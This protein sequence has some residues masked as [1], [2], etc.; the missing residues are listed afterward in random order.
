[1]IITTSKRNEYR[2]LLP[3]ELNDKVCDE[4]SGNNLKPVQQ[5]RLILSTYYKNNNDHGEMP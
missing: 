4:A 2:L 5:I 3:D 1:M